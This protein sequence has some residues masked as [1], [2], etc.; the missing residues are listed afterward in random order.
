MNTSTV[1]DNQIT[2]ANG[3]V[4][5][6]QET[7][8]SGAVTDTS[9][10]DKNQAEK[11]AIL[12]N[13][14]ATLPGNGATAST[15]INQ[16]TQSY[17]EKVRIQHSLFTKAATPSPI[18]ASIGVAS[19]AYIEIIR[20]HYMSDILHALQ[21]VQPHACTPSASVYINKVLH[22]IRDLEDKSPS[23]PILE[24]LFALY[25]ALAFDGLWATYTAEQYQVAEQV[26]MRVA[27]QSIS[28]NKIEN[29]ITAL[30][31]AGF[32]TMPYT[33]SLDDEDEG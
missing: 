27:N 25:D 28:T 15:T 23:D 17:A 18:L 20:T 14:F 6:G 13:L 26:L 24:I 9:F 31:E 5:A 3:S 1:I 16:N 32:D 4:I 33:F 2:S 22:I 19:E 7:N 21:K 30:E 10:S 11:A 29:A 8:N 12:N